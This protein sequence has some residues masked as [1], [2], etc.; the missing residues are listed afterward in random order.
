[1][2]INQLLDHQANVKNSLG[3]SVICFVIQ[4]MLSC[5]YQPIK[6]QIDFHKFRVTIFRIRF[7][8]EKNA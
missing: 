5:L 7:S 6:L 2:N 1:M 4:N 8:I 3:L